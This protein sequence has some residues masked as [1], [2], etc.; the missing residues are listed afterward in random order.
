[1]S[2]VSAP[3]FPP[4]G[5]VAERS[6]MPGIDVY[7]PA[8]KTAPEHRETIEFHCPVYATWS[9]DDDGP[10]Q[11]IIVNGRTGSCGVCGAHR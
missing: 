10:P 7:K 8:A 3:P 1:M 9:S 11:P 6:A 5:Y 2:A 4:P